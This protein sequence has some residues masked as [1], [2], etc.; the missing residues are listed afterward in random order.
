MSKGEKE[1]R[2]ERERAKVR[3]PRKYDLSSISV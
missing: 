2:G 3:N 1:S